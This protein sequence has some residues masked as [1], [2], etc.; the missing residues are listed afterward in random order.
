M[1]KSRRCPPALAS[2]PAPNPTA[3]S[4]PWSIRGAGA[5]S[6]MVG[7][8][9][10]ALHG[11]G[12]SCLQPPA[13]GLEAGRQTRG[14]LKEKIPSLLEGGCTS[15]HQEALGGSNQPY[16]PHQRGEGRRRQ[17]LHT[18]TAPAFG[19]GGRDTAAIPPALGKLRHSKGHSLIRGLCLAELR[20]GP[21]L[22]TRLKQRKTASHVCVPSSRAVP[23]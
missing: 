19:E 17:G 22:S 4:P 3:P 11:P 15:P 21:A 8:R 9:A 20:Q 16:F 14:D 7:H 6:P 12:L 13:P 5:P 2:C 10:P 23:G 1:Y 18:H